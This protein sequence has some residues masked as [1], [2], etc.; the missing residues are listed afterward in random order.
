MPAHPP[1]LGAR[2]V[3]RLGQDVRYDGS[4][5]HLGTLMMRIFCTIGGNKPAQASSTGGMYCPSKLRMRDQ[6]ET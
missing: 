2:R 5:T 6:S 1:A 4:V 3:T